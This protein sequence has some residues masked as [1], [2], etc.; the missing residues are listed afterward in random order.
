MRGEG[1]GK[2]SLFPFHFSH[3]FSECFTCIYLGELWRNRI[4]GAMSL[5]LRT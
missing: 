5:E 1:P 2:R 3:S 4:Q